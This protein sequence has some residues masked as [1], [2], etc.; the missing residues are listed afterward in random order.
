MVLLLHVKA[1]ESCKGHKRAILVLKFI[2]NIIAENLQSCLNPGL[3]NLY[4]ESFC[5]DG[6]PV[7]LS[8]PFYS[9]RSSSMRQRKYPS[10][11]AQTI[12][13]SDLV[14][15]DLLAESLNL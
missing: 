8:W 10:W 14:H 4:C 9:D 13:R 3:W 1:N 5:S 2:A 15:E 12:L 6:C 11:V 7:F